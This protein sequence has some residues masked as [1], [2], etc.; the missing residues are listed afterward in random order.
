MF[1][2]CKQRENNNLF[3]FLLNSLLYALFMSATVSYLY[4]LYNNNYNNNC[5]FV[6]L[7]CLQPFCKQQKV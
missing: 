2:D 7:I 3:Q 6:I 4:N 5:S 1:V